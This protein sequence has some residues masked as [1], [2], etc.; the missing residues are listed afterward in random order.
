MRALVRG[1]ASS[2]AA[3]QTLEPAAAGQGIVL[4]AARAQHDAYV[5]LLRSLVRSVTEVPADDKHPG[6]S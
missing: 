1:L 3:A 2:F 5:Q 6:A 4:A